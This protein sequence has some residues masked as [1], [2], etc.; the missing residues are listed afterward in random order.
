MA[1][2]APGSELVAN[3]LAEVLFIQTLRTHIASG[4]E[5]CKPDGARDF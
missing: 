2:Q 1:E 5:S 3:R 4:A